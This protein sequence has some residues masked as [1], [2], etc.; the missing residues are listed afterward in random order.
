[1]NIERCRALAWRAVSPLKPAITKSLTGIRAASRTQAGQNLPHYYLIYFLLVD[2]LRFKDLGQVEKVAW[3]VPVDLNGKVFMIEHRKLGV[4]VF[5]SRLPDDESDATEIVRLIRKGVKVARPYFDYRASQAV[6]SPHVNVVNNSKRLFERFSYFLDMY[7]KKVEEAERRKDERIETR[8]DYPNGGWGITISMPVYQ[9]RMEASWLALAVIECFFSWTEHIFV[10]LATMQGKCVTGE[11]VGKLAAADWTEKFK[12]ALDL[13]LPVTKSFFDDLIKVRRQLRNFVAHGSFGKEGEAFHFHSGAGA[14]PVRLPNAGSR[15]S[16]TFSSG[17]GF[18]DPD[19]IQLLQNFIEHLWSGPLGPARIYLQESSLPVIV[20]M[21]KAGDYLDAL[22][23]H[24]G[25]EQF[26]RY[27][28]EK[29]DRS[30][31]MDF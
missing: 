26:T 21:A 17:M 14:V 18:V 9:P 22:A 23:S 2:L 4:G 19:T 27:L 24:E 13:S 12:T 10:H 11:D 25:M 15:N 8:H 30:S 29:S 20:S 16:Y 5:A 31:N 6:L 3:S 7:T 1:M 28:E